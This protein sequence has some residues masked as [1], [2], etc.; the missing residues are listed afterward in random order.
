MVYK[1]LKTGEGAKVHRLEMLFMA[2]IRTHF[3]CIW[4]SYSTIYARQESLKKPILTIRRN[5]HGFFLAP[6]GFEIWWSSLVF[7][8]WRFENRFRM[9]FGFYQYTV[10]DGFDVLVL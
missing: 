10:V 3:L 4:S 6:T 7:V 1:Y 9:I 5:I 8:C 2:E